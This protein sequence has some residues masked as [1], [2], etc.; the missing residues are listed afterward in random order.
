MKNF[1]IGLI[2]AFVLIGCSTTTKSQAQLT[3]RLV[4]H[5]IDT[6]RIDSKYQKDVGTAEKLMAAAEKYRKEGKDILEAYSWEQALIILL[7]IDKKR[8]DAKK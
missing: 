5:G 3:L 4:Q 1:L 8:Y 2:L 7:E 6:E